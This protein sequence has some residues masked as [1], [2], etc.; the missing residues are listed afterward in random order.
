MSDLV[1]GSGGRLSRSEREQRA[2][3]LVLA[4]GGAAAVAVAG[5]VLAVVGVVGFWLP[6][7]AIVVAAICGFLFRRTI[8]S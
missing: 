2:Y 1:P 6:V 7:L 8:E 3:R 5:V 4:G